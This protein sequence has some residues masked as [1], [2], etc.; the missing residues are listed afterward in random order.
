VN[1]AYPGSSVGTRAAHTGEQDTYLKKHN[2]KGRKRVDTSHGHWG[3]YFLQPGQKCVGITGNH[4]QQI[5]FQIWKAKELEPLQSRSPRELSGGDKWARWHPVPAHCSWRACLITG[6]L[7][8]PWALP[9][10]HIIPPALR[11][12]TGRSEIFEFP[13]VRFRGLKKWGGEWGGLVLFLT[14]HHVW[15]PPGF[16]CTEQWQQLAW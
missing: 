4:Y 12:T 14:R 6:L 7:F 16:Q 11:I 5:F 10:F 15:R 1:K 13:N 8:Q 2:W 3:C 9:F